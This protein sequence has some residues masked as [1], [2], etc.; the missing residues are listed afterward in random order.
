MQ[1]SSHPNSA[2]HLH[3]CRTVWRPRNPSLRHTRHYRGHSWCEGSSRPFS[4]VLSLCVS[5]SL[6]QST[7]GATTNLESGHSA[8]GCCCR[9]HLASSCRRGS[10]R[11]H[12]SLASDVWSLRTSVS[13][14]CLYLYLFRWWIINGRVL[15]PSAARELCGNRV[16][17]DSA[18]APVR[19]PI[20]R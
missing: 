14:S 16:N 7:Q 19:Y 10:S 11:T 1:P 8:W 2:S 3:L 17:I 15:K 5:S 13:S 12:Q 6:P 4:A 20:A 9:H 18:L